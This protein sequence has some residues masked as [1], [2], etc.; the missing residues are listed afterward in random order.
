MNKHILK[1]LPLLLVVFI[2]GN[3]S[4]QVNE[5]PGVGKVLKVNHSNGDIVVQTTNDTGVTQMGTR[6]YTRI[7]GK[8]VII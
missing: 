4:A 8:V 2:L 5:D 6:L 3:I 7:D 1:L